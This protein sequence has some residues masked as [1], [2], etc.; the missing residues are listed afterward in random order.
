MREYFALIVEDEEDLG[1]I[2]QEATRMAGFT[3]T[4]I[5]PNGRDAVRFLETSTPDVV[6][7]DLH[8]PGLDGAQVL[9]WVKS[10]PHLE[11][12][13]VVL[14]TADAAMADTLEDQ[15]DFVLLKPV[16]FSQLRDLSIR[17]L[18]AVKS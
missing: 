11:K 10:Q 5:I 18:N 16:S 15:A 2:F 8:L 4:K 7:L 6:I 17:F 12:T 14:A 3:I 13:L 9:A 1:V